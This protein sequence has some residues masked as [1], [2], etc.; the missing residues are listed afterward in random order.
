MEVFSTV[1]PTV[2][3]AEDMEAATTLPL[4]LKAAHHGVMVAMVPTAVVGTTGAGAAT[5][6]AAIAAEEVA[7]GDMVTIDGT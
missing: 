2:E 4:T 5:E 7:V 1:T 3:L 6:A